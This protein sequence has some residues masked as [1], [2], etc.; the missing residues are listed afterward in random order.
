MQKWPKFNFSFLEINWNQFWD[1]LHDQIILKL[2][3]NTFRILQNS[4][5]DH[6]WRDFINIGVFWNSKKIQSSNAARFRRRAK[7]KTKTNQISS[8]PR[9]FATFEVH[10]TTFSTNFFTKM[11]TTSSTSNSNSTIQMAAAQ[12]AK[13]GESNARKK[14]KS[15][16]FAWIRIAQKA[17]MI[18]SSL[19]NLLSFRILEVKVKMAENEKFAKSV[20]SKLGKLNL[21]DFVPKR[22]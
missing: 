8:K 11:D 22:S 18:M 14:S 5:F 4:Y 1:T 19:P 6:F 3:L 21:L 7:L 17:K 20:L 10:F 12:M 15:I 16:G 13:I 2:K 9:H